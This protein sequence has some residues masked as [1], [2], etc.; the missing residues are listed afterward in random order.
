MAFFSRNNNGNDGQTTPQTTQT[1]RGIFGKQVPVRQQSQPYTPQTTPAFRVTTSNGTQYTLDNRQVD[2]IRSRYKQDGADTYGWDDADQYARKTGQLSAKM[3]STY[4]N[5][6]VDRQLA[7]LGLPSEKNLE[8]YLGQ[9]Q[10]WHTGGISDY[11]GKDVPQDFYT[12]TKDMFKGDWQYDDTQED[13]L[14]KSSGQMPSKLAAKYTDTEIDDELRAAGLPPVAEMG[15]YIGRYNNYSAIDNL[16]KNA[17][18]AWANLGISQDDNGQYIQNDNKLYTVNGL[19]RKGKD[20][21]ADAFYDEMGRKDANGND[22]YGSI[23]GLF[24]NN[25]LEEDPDDYDGT[26]Y[27]QYRGKQFANAAKVADLAD[28]YAAYTAFSYDD[29][30]GKYGDYYDKFLKNYKFSDG[31]TL[32]ERMKGIAIKNDE[33]AQREFYDVSDKWLDKGRGTSDFVARYKQMYP[34]N[35]YEQMFTDMFENGVAESTILKTMKTL[36][37]DTSVTGGKNNAEDKNS[38]FNDITDA[39]YRAKQNFKSEQ[40]VNEE[41]IAAEAEELTAED[42]VRRIEDYM[43]ESGGWTAENATKAM[44]ALVE[45]P[46]RTPW[47]ICVHDSATPSTRMLWTP[48]AHTS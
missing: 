39:F 19:T 30:A 40:R 16:Y 12:K 33:Q 17:A 18:V 36:R 29:F 7:E 10:N 20:L 9:Y 5:S 32:E 24:K 44:D 26:N 43:S 25:H 23:Y 37:R 31:Q 4:G 13:Q 2:W 48:S 27:N 14:R 35:T 15:K 6:N 45:A 21:Y 47:L 38:G 1:Q 8:K 11:F 28:D 22:V 3:R 41:A 34:S 42:A 46:S